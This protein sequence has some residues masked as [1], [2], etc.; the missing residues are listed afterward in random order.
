M[1]RESKQEILYSISRNKKVKIGVWPE[2]NIVLVHIREYY[3]QDSQDLPGKKGIALDIDQWQK[4]V[5]HI[6]DIDEDVTEMQNELERAT[7]N[8]SKDDEDIFDNSNNFGTHPN[9]Y[10]HSRLLS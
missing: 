5:A 4:L 8:I 1:T 3:K 10:G 9:Q 6:N 7:S 2:K